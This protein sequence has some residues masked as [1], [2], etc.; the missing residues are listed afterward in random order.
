MLFA[1]ISASSMASARVLSPMMSASWASAIA[2]AS[3]SDVTIRLTWSDI[4]PTRLASLAIS[5]ATSCAWFSAWSITV[6]RASNPSAAATLIMATP[7]D[8]VTIT[9]R[10]RDRLMLLSVR[11]TCAKRITNAITPAKARNHAIA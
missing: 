10:C 1:V 8:A 2:C 5:P 4:T 7:T 11:R 3:F 9:I 6:F